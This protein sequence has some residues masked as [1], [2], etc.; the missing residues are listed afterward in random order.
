M[1]N[2]A[3]SA[4]TVRVTLIFGIILSLV[5]YEKFH[6]TAGGAIVP[7]YLAFA[8]YRPLSIVL[9][10]AAGYLT[11]L[12]TT[13][14]IAKRWLL[15]G[16]RKFEIE[17]IVGL[18]FI[19]VITALGSLLG[20]F[21]LLSVTLTGIGFL[22]PGI[23]AHDMTRQKPGRTMLV[24]GATSVVIAVFMVTYETL[25][26]ITPGAHTT[27]V[28]LASILGYPR[29]LLLVGVGFS[30][31]L[32]MLLFSKLGLRSGGF[33]TGAY[34]ALVSPRWGDIVFTLVV[35]VL[36][37]CVVVKLLMPRLLIFGRRKMAT[38]LMVGAVI[39]WSAELFLVQISN[40]DYVPW[41]GLTIATLLVPSLIAND[42]QRQG[43]ERTLYG[44]T[45]NAF[46]VFT[47][48]SLCSA[49]LAF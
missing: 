44:T 1:D 41:R 36:I 3:V 6:L 42:A 30:V 21:D 39:G 48:A 45:L 24:I 4:D 10:I 46:G 27:N 13:K 40:G 49:I 25:V 11:Y 16:R 2:Y 38:M 22:I 26:M 5:I 19:L 47:L 32:G 8:I 33:V 7:A 29:Q 28:D 35:S 9:T 34:L 14:F 18:L 12:V 37:W 31:V 23:I 15:Y 20:K 43:W 17:V